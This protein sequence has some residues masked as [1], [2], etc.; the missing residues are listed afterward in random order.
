VAD[1]N[2]ASGRHPGWT[3]G[4]GIHLTPK[5]CLGFTRV[6]NRAVHDATWL[7]PYFPMRELGGRR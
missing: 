4:D 6:V 7:M 3:W 5:G 2:D 1:W